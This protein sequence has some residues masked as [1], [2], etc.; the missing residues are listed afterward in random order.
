MTDV[1]DVTCL[2]AIYILTQEVTVILGRKNK[3]KSTEYRD[4]L[5][6]NPNKYISHKTYAAFYPSA[7]T[8]HTNVNP[9][10]GQHFPNRIP[11]RGDIWFAEL[12]D[13]PGTSVQGG[14]RPVIVVSNDIGNEWAET[15]NVLPMTRHLKRS[16]LPCHTELAPENVDDK[17]QVFDPSMILAEQIATV[18]KTQL[19]SYVGR[20]KNPAILESINRSV[21][22]Q[23]ELE[24]HK[25]SM[26]T[27]DDNCPDDNGLD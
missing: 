16:D 18:S 9:T 2:P 10:F 13:H 7:H 4:R 5:G 11:R 23:L 20:V 19:R 26:P 14:C 24:E 25:S 22:V 1:T 3:R 17:Q 27:A 8:A 12:G 15:I 21:A 6:F